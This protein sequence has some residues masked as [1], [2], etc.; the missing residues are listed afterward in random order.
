MKNLIQENL[1]W[2]C[3][4]YFD[5][6]FLLTASCKSGQNKRSL[7]K[8]FSPALAFKY[9]LNDTT[10][11][12]FHPTLT[13]SSHAVFLSPGINW[14]VND[15]MLSCSHSCWWVQW[16]EII[17][18]RASVVTSYQ[19]LDMIPDQWRPAGKWIKTDSFHYFRRGNILINNFTKAV[20]ASLGNWIIYQ[21]MVLDNQTAVTP[22]Q[23]ELTLSWIL[24]YQ[25]PIR[26]VCH[27]SRRPAVIE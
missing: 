14:F 10:E 9:F 11:I 16:F 2:N 15:K 22:F 7:N 24:S 23:G 21:Y 8:Y 12:F 4:I 27:E 3:W 20:R 17:L 13:E 26:M 1:H 6:I 25:F 19:A 5:P 18:Y